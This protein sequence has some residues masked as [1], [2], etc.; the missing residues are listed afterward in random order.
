MTRKL[1]STFLLLLTLL[2][3]A[4]VV[5]ADIARPKNS[6]KQ[7]PISLYSS[8]EIVP[9]AKVSEAKLQISQDTLKSLHA[10]LIDVPQNP[11]FAQRV[12]Q[13]SPRTMIAGFF[14]FM[15]ISIAGVLLVRSGQ[16]GQKLAALAILSAALLGAA[17]IITRANA[18][19]P[20]YA[21]WQKL[22]QALTDGR[23]TSGGVEIE[24]VPEGRGIKLIVPQRNNKPNPGE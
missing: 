11:T 21:I 12:A 13:S 10:G 2:G 9:D 18:G 3:V 20:G 14:L 1:F 17:T 7:R 23:S 16:K 19:P 4:I 15:S 6:P 22:P 5:L 24:I 8:L